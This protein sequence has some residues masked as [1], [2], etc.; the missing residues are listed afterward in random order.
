MIHLAVGR[1][2]RWAFM[3]SF[4]KVVVPLNDYQRLGCQKRFIS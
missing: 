4:L 2:R 1:I 3:N